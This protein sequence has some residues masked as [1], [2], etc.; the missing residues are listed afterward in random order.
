MPFETDGSDVAARAVLRSERRVIVNL[1]QHPR[2]EP[3]QAGVAQLKLA[4]Q[5]NR[6]VMLSEAKHL[7]MYE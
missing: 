2:D 6:H 7:G 1:R 5:P 3:W 4:L